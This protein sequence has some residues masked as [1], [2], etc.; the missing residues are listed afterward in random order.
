[1]AQNDSK[2]SEIRAAK[3]RGYGKETIFSHTSPT[4]GSAFDMLKGRRLQLQNRRREHRDG[5][6]E[7]SICDGRLDA[8]FRT[9]REYPAHEL[10]KKSVSAMRFPRT[11]HRTGCRF[12]RIRKSDRKTVLLEGIFKKF[13]KKY[14]L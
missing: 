5:T 10:R 2:L 12:C 6:K 14:G 11:A 9:S 3:S 13:H 7:R 8:F 4:Y 1:M